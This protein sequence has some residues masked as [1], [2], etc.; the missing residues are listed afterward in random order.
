MRKFGWVGMS[1]VTFFMLVDRVNAF[2]ISPTRFLVTA[3][4]NSQQVVELVVANDEKVEKKFKILIGGLKQEKNGALL[5][6]INSDQAEVWVRPDRNEVSLAANTSA[7]IKFIISIPD[8]VSPG[9]HY[10]GLAAEEE[11]GTT[12][13]SSLGGRLFSILTLRVAGE[14][15]ESV[16]IDKWI[17]PT[18]IMS[19]F[20][21]LK[22]QI[23][24]NGSIDVP[25]ES[26]VKISYGGKILNNDDWILGNNLLTGS[27]RY[28]EKIFNPI[29]LWPGRY[30]VQNKITYGRSGQTVWASCYVWYFPP[31]S[32]FGSLILFLAIILG[33]FKI[34][35]GH[36]KN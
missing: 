31:W 8:G 17:G 34:R 35:H 10:L 11:A 7:V 32:I 36:V 5:F 15:V 24:N 30:D 9:S 28:V 3:N 21:P 25:I 26:N 18:I 20:W 19:S 29:L 4:P 12:T 16:S 13:G 33:Y 23:N 22:L 6:E 14:V 1:V 2:S 27:S